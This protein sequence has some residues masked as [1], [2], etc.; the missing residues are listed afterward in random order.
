MKRI[1]TLRL[2]RFMAEIL[3]LLQQRHLL[4]DILRVAKFLLEMDIIRSALLFQLRK[5]IQRG[6]DL[7][8]QLM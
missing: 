7:A 6:T 4:H 3:L 5:H 1:T 2:S 8:E